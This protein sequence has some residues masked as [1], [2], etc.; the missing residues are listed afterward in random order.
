MSAG[1]RYKWQGSRVEVTTAFSASAK[2]IT[3]ITKANPAVVSITA[4]GYAKG[5][6][7]KLDDIVGMEELNGRVCIVGDVTTDTIELFGVDSTGYGTYTSGGEAVA[8]T[9]SNFCELTGY[10]RQGGST[11]QIDATTIC[12]TAAEKEAGLPDYGTT[13]LDY[14]HA[15]DVA[16]QQA[17]EAAHAAGDTI[18]VRV[19]LP[20][21]GG[22]MVQLGTIQ[23]TSEQSSNGNLWTGSLTISNTGGRVYV[24]AA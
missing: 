15:P 22:T 14:H 7:I 24:E 12:S 9:W 16:V 5:A 20:R 13:Q 10:N 21:N 23:Q 18:G 8:G 6:V 2:T 3:A 4:H 17:L 11:P 1:K 19:V